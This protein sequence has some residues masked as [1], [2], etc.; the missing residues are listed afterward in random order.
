MN[1]VLWIVQGLLALAFL[2]AGGMKAFAPA[3]TLKKN[4]PW[5]TN[6][7]VWV[8][9]LGIAEILGAIG[10]I[11]PELT[12]ILPWLTIAAAVG[13]AIVGIGAVIFHGV[14]K[15]YNSIA[16]TVILFLLALF[17][18]IGRLTLAPL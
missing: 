9:L 6:I 8:R 16:P 17:A 5:A 15:E 3:E 18:I 2:F 14:R 1:I 11:L 13:L 12:H 7:L 4:M 10:I